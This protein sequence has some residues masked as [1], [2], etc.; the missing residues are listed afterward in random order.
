MAPM[1]RRIV[2]HEQAIEPFG[3]GN[4]SRLLGSMG[5]IEQF[6]G[7]VAGIIDCKDELTVLIRATTRL[8]DLNVAERAGMKPDSSQS[9][10]RKPFPNFA[11]GADNFRQANPVVEQLGDLT[12][13]CEV[14]KAETTIPL[15]Q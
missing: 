15:V 8:L 11:H 1:H 10:I 12:G 4:V 13:T 9:G 7:I 14:A 6:I 2:F 5:P 3:F